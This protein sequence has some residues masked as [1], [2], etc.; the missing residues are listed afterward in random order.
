MRIGEQVR[1][2]VFDLVLDA[3]DRTCHDRPRLPHRLGHG[4][5]EALRR[6]FW[7]TTSRA[8]E[9]RSRPRRSPRGR[10]SR[11]GEMD[12]SLPCLRQATPSRLHFVEDLGPF[13]IVCDGWAPGPAS[14]RCASVRAARAPQSPSS[15]RADLSSGPSGRPGR[16]ADCRAQRAPRPAL[17]AHRPSTRPGLPSWRVNAGVVPWTVT[18]PRR[19][20]GA[21]RKL[22]PLLVLGREQ[23]DRRLDDLGSN[24]PPTGT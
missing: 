22:R 3:A 16:P 13:G 15:R 10:S 4:Q 8:A 9:A 2:A 12:A 14:M 24:R 6:L 11:G 21:A 23:V 1:S 7:T 5:A 20:H 19:E 17:E 18:S